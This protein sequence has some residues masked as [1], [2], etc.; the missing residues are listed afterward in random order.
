VVL[1][2]TY[3]TT[4]PGKEDMAQL[5]LV[6]A[7]ETG[8]AL[9]VFYHEALADEELQRNLRN[10]L[11]QAHESLHWSQGLTLILVSWFT[12]VGDSGTA[13]LCVTCT[14]WQG[15]GSCTSQG[16]LISVI[17]QL[18]ANSN[19]GER[20]WHVWARKAHLK[21]KQASRITFL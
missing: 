17:A 3:I 4:D 8:I 5:E 18:V 1:R 12:L 2:S 14:P 13:L 11:S 10:F 21:G 15:Q 20:C 19:S 16:A 9:K 7:L 6:Q